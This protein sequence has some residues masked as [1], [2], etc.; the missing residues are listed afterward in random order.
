VDVGAKAELYAIIN[1]LAE[2]GVG[3]IMISSELP[4]IIGMSDRV[5]VMHNG[6][7]AG[8]LI[9]GELNQEKIMH[10]ATGGVKDAS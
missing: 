4:E 2:Q 1:M 5:L 10:L 3:I 9:R 8:S 7:I 6:R